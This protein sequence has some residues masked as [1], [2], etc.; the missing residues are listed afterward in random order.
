[1]YV[2]CTHHSTLGYFFTAL[3]RI[4][5]VAGYFCFSSLRLDVFS[6][7]YHYW[8]ANYSHYITHKR[9]NTVQKT[10]Y[11]NVKYELRYATPTLSSMPSVLPHKLCHP[12]LPTCT[13]VI[14]DRHRTSAYI[15]HV[16]LRWCLAE[17]SKLPCN[18][19]DLHGH[20]QCTTYDELYPSERQRVNQKPSSYLQTRPFFVAA[21]TYPRQD[22]GRFIRSVNSRRT[23]RMSGQAGAS[24]VAE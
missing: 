20:V 3:A 10:H 5:G 6:R 4:G 21:G 18:A 13:V 9:S 19:G 17:M 11:E 16:V 15:N 14:C 2:L 8:T 24:R 1:L 22:V 7:F 23:R 12:S